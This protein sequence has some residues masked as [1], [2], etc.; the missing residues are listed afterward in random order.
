MC[1]ELSNNLKI[2]K[3]AL[4]RFVKEKSEDYVFNEGINHAAVLMSTLMDNTKREI[5]MFCQGFGPKLIKDETYKNSLKK[6]LGDETKIIKIL[7]VSRDLLQEPSN[8]SF[9]VL[10]EAYK[11]RGGKGIELYEISEGCKAKLFQDYNHGISC[12]FSVFDNNMFRLENFPDEYKAVAS[13]N[14]VKFSEKLIES[15]DAALDDAK[16]KPGL[17]LSPLLTVAEEI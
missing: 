7:V 1:V 16:Q 15:F 12:N 10:K 5:R 17:N 9:K 13:F 3:E 2:Y 8:E 14:N 6:Y 11:K 4:D